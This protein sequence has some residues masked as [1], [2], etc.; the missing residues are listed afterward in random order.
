MTWPPTSLH[1]TFGTPTTTAEE[2]K[3][4]GET[5][6]IKLA[7]KWDIRYYKKDILVLN[8][9]GFTRNNKIKIERRKDSLR[10]FLY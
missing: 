9:A 10:K 6:T 2:I 5:T 1:A 8:D 7:T 3:A 4:N